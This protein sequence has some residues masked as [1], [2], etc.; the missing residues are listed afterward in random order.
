[1]KEKDMDELLLYSVN[2]D[3]EICIYFKGVG[4]GL[5]KYEPKNEAERVFLSEVLPFELAHLEKDLKNKFKNQIANSD[6]LKK[7]ENFVINKLKVRFERLVRKPFDSLTVSV[8][9]S[10]CMGQI[11]LTFYWKGRQIDTIAT[12]DYEVS[13]GT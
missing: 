2:K 13:D 4:A 9:V 1:M 10:S 6:T 8:S 7:V 12:D 3:K 11:E 5:E